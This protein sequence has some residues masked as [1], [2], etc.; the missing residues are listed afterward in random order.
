MAWFKRKDKGIQTPTEDKKDTPKG[1]WYKTPSGKIIDTEELKSNLFV[2]PEDGYH[3]RIG[4]KEY[5][6][7]FFDDN[8]FKELNPNLTSLD[9]LKFED[10]KKY[11]DR[12]KEATEK[13]NLMTA[14]YVN[15]KKTLHFTLNSIVLNKKNRP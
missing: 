8:T 15:L 13:N 12:V 7:I 9:P 3:V 11:T 14:P 4:S 2:S 5:F 1:L 10:T 6:E